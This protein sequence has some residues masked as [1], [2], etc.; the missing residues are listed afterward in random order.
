MPTFSGH[1]D[2]HDEF[3]AELFD[4]HS[5]L[6][7]FLDP[8]QRLFYETTYEAIYDAGYDPFSIGGYRSGCFIGS[9]Y[10]DTQFA[11]FEEIT[12]KSTK[13][14]ERNAQFVCDAFNLKGVSLQI[15]KC[16]N[17]NFDFLFRYR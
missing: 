13:F 6:A 3:D 4:V 14:F 15:Y 5:D 10:N 12:E 8:Q 2:F 17:F 9:C 7:N 11:R 1:L 16:I